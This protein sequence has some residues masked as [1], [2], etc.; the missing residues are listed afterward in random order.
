MKRVRAWVLLL[1]ME[2]VVIFF[3]PAVVVTGMVVWE[4]PGRWLSLWPPHQKW[5]DHGLTDWFGWEGTFR[6]HPV[7]PPA[8]GRDISNQMRVLRAP[9]N[10]AWNGSRD[11]ASP[12]SLGNLGQGLTILSVNNFFLTPSLSL[13]SSSLKL[14]PFLLSLQ[15]LVKSLPPSFL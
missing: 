3:L 12:T 13:P 4:Q 14:L 2:V 6:G 10:L 11:G 5:G 1:L 9:S 8:M 7:Q 15:T